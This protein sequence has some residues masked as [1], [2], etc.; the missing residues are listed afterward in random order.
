MSETWTDRERVVVLLRRH[1]Q[2]VVAAAAAVVLLI[3]LGLMLGSRTF[4]NAAEWAAALG[5]IA[6]FAA[7]V[8][9]LR[10]EVEARRRDIEERERRQAALVSC[11]LGEQEVMGQ[12][13]PWEARSVFVRNAS[14]EPIY[15]AVIT[16]E[17]DHYPSPS[18]WSV[19]GPQQE[20]HD[21]WSPRVED[22]GP[23]VIPQPV[24]SFLDAA[25]LAWERD[26][27]GRLARRPF[28]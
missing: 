21:Q 3:G 24:L 8:A 11:W 17:P 15:H 6:A 22:L 4:G 1:R 13:K 16:Q 26:G 9:L 25:G 2:W 18:T 19:I 12:A 7:T 28:T 10:Q 23:G 20:V 27:R 14:E 5:T